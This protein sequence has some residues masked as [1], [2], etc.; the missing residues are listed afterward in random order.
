MT[1]SNATLVEGSGVIIK[2]TSGS[3]QLNWAV[4][5]ERKVVQIGDDLIVY[6]LGMYSVSLEQ[7]NESLKGNRTK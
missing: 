6:L 5:A 3:L 7:C 2:L 1:T 4:T